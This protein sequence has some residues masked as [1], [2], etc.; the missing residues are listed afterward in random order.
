MTPLFAEASIAIFRNKADHDTSTR[1]QVPQSIFEAAKR[2]EESKQ[3][4]IIRT[5]MGIF[6]VTFSETGPFIEKEV[7]DKWM[8]VAIYRMEQWASGGI[9]LSELEAYE[10]RQKDTTTTE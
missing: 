3:T 9:K 7:A 2:V 10:L 8:Q 5:N 4:E 6:V 1:P